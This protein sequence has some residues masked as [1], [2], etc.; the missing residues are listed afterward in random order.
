VALTIAFL[1]LVGFTSTRHAT[2]KAIKDFNIR[3]IMFLTD[4]GHGVCLAHYI[5]AAP[6]HFVK[7]G[8]LRHGSDRHCFRDAFFAGIHALVIVSILAVEVLAVLITLVM[9]TTF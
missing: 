4:L 8:L 9:I 5:I 7:K 2:G 1:C 6:N 3:T